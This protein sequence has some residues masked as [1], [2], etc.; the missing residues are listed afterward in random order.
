MSLSS[1]LAVIM[2]GALVTEGTGYLWHRWACHAGVFQPFFKDILRRRHFDHHTSKYAGAGLR[3]DTYF[4]SCDIAFR[5]LGLGLVFLVI[6]LAA[7]NWIR[8]EVSIAFLVGIFAHAFL[9]TKLHT[10]YHLSDKSARRSTFLRWS[11]VWKAFSWLRDFHDVHHV[12]NANYSLALPLFDIIGGT[13]I[14]PKKLTE[15]RAENLFPRFDSG[16]SS[17]CEGPLF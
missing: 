4:Q 2:I 3:H 13:Y 15:L 14:S 7:I 9:G 16:L 12:A 6:T 5:V 8:L 11:L 10:L 17:S 1:R